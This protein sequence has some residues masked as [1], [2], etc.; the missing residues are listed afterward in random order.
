MEEKAEEY[1]S[2]QP[3]WQK[4]EVSNFGNVRK[5]GKVLKASP[6]SNGYPR[7]SLYRTDN[8]KETRHYPR[9]HRLVA[10]Y[11]IPML[12]CKPYVNH[13]DG[14]K[15]NN[16]VNNL[17]W[18]TFTE[19]VNHAFNED[20]MGTNIKCE[21][22]GKAYRSLTEAANAFG[23]RQSTFSHFLKNGIESWKIIT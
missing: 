4:Y 7:V 22:N 16:H 12:L 21:I 2:L 6:E 10:Q 19:N 17:E 3:P 23:M 14:N 8:G 20:L 9:V 5:G 18:S 15:L 11:F 13:L 1:K